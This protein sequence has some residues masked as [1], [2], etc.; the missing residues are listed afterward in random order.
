MQEK[1]IM[2]LEVLIVTII[3]ALIL[4][5]GLRSYRYQQ[6]AVGI[7]RAHNTAIKIRAAL[8]DYYNTLSCNA[9]GIL[10]SD[11]D[12]DIIDQLNVTIPPSQYIKQYHAYIQPSTQVTHAGKPIYRLHVTAEIDLMYQAAT[13][14]LA[15]R[16]HAR[17]VKRNLIEWDALPN[18][19][20]AQS[21]GVLWV[22]N[23]RR[24]RFKQFHN[25]KT[26]NGGHA[27]HA[28]CYR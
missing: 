23:T 7:M 9:Q 3:A 14:W 2:I 5:L 10:E 13:T 24:E 25:N 18:T 19:T 27:T 22:L 21:G 12:E 28:Y 16:L 26:L 1:G 15:Q 17:F 11:T 6:H 8:N 4:G 20:M